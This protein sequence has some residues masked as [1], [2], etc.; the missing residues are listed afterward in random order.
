MFWCITD[1]PGCDLCISFI[2]WVHLLN[3][4]ERAQQYLL[5]SWLSLC[6]L[7]VFPHITSIPRFQQIKTI[8]RCD[9]WHNLLQLPWCCLKSSPR[10]GMSP[11]VKAGVASA[12]S[13]AERSAHGQTG[14]HHCA[15][16]GYFLGFPD[17][18]VEGAFTHCV[19]VWGCDK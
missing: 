8:T 6:L 2:T 1:Q 5:F 7:S 14:T 10:V 15:V 17:A 18:A 12:G 9:L 11:V 4:S 13:A 16:S 19:C 3:Y